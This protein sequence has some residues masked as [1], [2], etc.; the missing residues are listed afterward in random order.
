MLCIAYT[1]NMQYIILPC[2]KPKG[3]SCLGS[4][5][6]YVVK[7][8]LVKMN[9]LRVQRF[10]EDCKT[11]NLQREGFYLPMLFVQPSR[12]EGNAGGRPCH[13]N[14]MDTWRCTKRSVGFSSFGTIQ[15]GRDPR[16]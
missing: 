15:R 3:K 13:R 10:F 14:E 9:F 12:D 2:A 5:A 8:N 7:L 6:S 4:G 1:F 11:C 16:S